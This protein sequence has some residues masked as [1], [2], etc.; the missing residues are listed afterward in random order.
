MKKKEKMAK[1]KPR[2]STQ[3]LSRENN[4]AENVKWLT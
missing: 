2:H 1:L 3:G 4:K